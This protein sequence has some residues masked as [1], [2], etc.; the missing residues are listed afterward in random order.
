MSYCYVRYF[1]V[2][3]SSVIL[4]RTFGLVLMLSNYYTL[5][6]L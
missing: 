3:R 4:L 1:A 6:I 2:I 5:L